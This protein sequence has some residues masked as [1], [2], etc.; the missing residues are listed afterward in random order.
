[1]SG[2]GVRKVKDD[3]F[4]IEAAATRKAASNG[5]L[6]GTVQGFGN[7]DRRMLGVLRS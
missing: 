6:G 4:T 7:R 3:G 5:F 2:H 1:M